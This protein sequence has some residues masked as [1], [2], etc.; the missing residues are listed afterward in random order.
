MCSLTPKPIVIQPAD[1]LGPYHRAEALRSLLMKHKPK[2]CVEVG[3]D[4]GAG[5]VF[6]AK[7]I[8]EWD[9]RLFCV[10]PWTD[11]VGRYERFCTNI[12]AYGMQDIVTPVRLSSVAAAL[13]TN[14]LVDLVYIDADHSYEMVS[15]DLQHWYPHVKSGGVICGDDY[16]MR[17]VRE[18]WGK[19]AEDIGLKIDS[20]DQVVFGVKE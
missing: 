16:G 17:P 14:D 19:F 4:A 18:A 9:G 13:K 20:R 15:L 8:K 12:W 3:S 5:A 10:D 2:R 6:I 7:H 1:E 11:D